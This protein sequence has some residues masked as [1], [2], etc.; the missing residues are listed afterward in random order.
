MSLP[1]SF[2][3]S[4]FPLPLSLPF[5][6]LDS[7]KWDHITSV[8]QLVSEIG[9]PSHQSLCEEPDRC[10]HPESSELGEIKTGQLLEIKNNPRAST[11]RLDGN[12]AKLLLLLRSAKAAV[13]E[14]EPI[15]LKNST[16]INLAQDPG[17]SSHKVS[18]NTLKGSDTKKGNS[19]LYPSS[20]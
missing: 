6:S 3:P 4:H 13:R 16:G 10:G 11:V 1:P 5:H 14:R 8:V 9:S 17:W 18:T 15:K 19:I 7:I 12:G 20:Q 2:P